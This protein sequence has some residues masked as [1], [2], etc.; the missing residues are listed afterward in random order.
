MTLPVAYPGT[1][2]PL[3]VAAG[4]VAAPGLAFAGDLD[5][6][7]Y[8][9]EADTVGIASSGKKVV[10]AEY[11]LLN[12][13]QDNA[14]IFLG[15]GQAVSSETNE[16]YIGT[17]SPTSA[18]ISG[19]LS[20]YVGLNIG[21]AII[22]ATDTTT[23]TSAQLMIENDFLQIQ[24]T[25]GAVQFDRAI[26]TRVR[27]AI[28]KTGVTLVDNIGISFT[29]PNS[30]DVSGA[31]T[32]YKAYHVPALTGGGGTNFY[33]VYFEN[34]P[35]GGSVTG[36]TNVPI[37]IV[38]QGTAGVVNINARGASGARVYLKT[39]DRTLVEL[40]TVGASLNYISLTAN[41]EPLILS[42]HASTANLSIG[43]SSKGNADVNIY[44]G[45]QGV[46]GFTVSHTV[47]GVNR[48][49]ATAGA[50]GVG[51]TLSVIGETNADM[52]LVPAGNGVVSFG[53]YTADGAAAIAGYITI[54]DAAGN[55][56]KLLVAA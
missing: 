5:T 54:K 55:S 16:H 50:T 43:I 28:P 18:D 26:N 23:K 12:T 11:R 42:G 44:T 36:G 20:S 22:T 29:V 51:P 14:K 35:N 13:N 56:R 6:G 15:T 4:T 40:G 48:L 39:N 41:N 37:S 32:N 9:P 45:S 46:K 10:T 53:T 17:I 30:G 2:G 21:N 49:N 38:G 33:G 1:G 25:G 7:L 24:Q 3:A 8:L 27:F 47:S 52:K 31:V 19:A 34:E